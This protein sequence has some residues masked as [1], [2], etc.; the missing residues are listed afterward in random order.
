MLSDKEIRDFYENE[1]KGVLLRFEKYRK[2][3]LLSKRLSKPLFWSV[4][5]LFLIGGV[6]DESVY[7]IIGAVLFVILFALTTW[8]LLK[9]DTYTSMYKADVVKKLLQFLAPSWKYIPN[10]HISK[11]HY[12]NCVILP[13]CNL[14]KGEDYVHGVIGDT[15]FEFSEVTAIEE[16]RDANNK[17]TEKTLYSGLFFRAEFSK[18]FN[19]ETVVV[20]DKME[21][22]LGYVVRSLQKNKKND[23]EIAFMEN[24]NFEREFIVR[25]SDQV[26]ARYLLTPQ[27]MEAIV[28][29]KLKYKNEISIVFAKSNL[30]LLV[31][32]CDFFEPNIRV[33]GGM[34]FDDVRQIVSII[35]MNKYI[36]K[37]FN[38]GALVY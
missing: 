13:K 27:I 6:I 3:S 29:Y 31:P 22:K 32:D 24:A 14:F 23:L 30:Y 38:Q 36:V 5:L 17:K 25:T 10:K 4:I 28:N 20:P 18:P 37:E 34:T 1:L 33:K 12:N 16:G 7:I 21:K 35:E 19:G 11:K 9:N 26:E 15:E 8:G 2:I